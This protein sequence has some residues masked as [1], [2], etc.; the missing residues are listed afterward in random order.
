MKPT[1]ENL[2]NNGVIT[3]CILFIGIFLAIGVGWFIM[4]NTQF[5]DVSAEIQ[6]MIHGASYIVIA[7]GCC[8]IG[9]GILHGKITI[10]EYK[11]E[12]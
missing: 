12:P 5:T 2:F 4:H 1:K 11:K 8:I 10:D 3:L 6:W 9:L 7:S